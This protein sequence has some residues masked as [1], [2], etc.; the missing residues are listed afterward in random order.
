MRAVWKLGNT[1]RVYEAQSVCKNYS[2]IAG[3][4]PRRTSS[5]GVLAGH[6]AMSGS[7]ALSHGVPLPLHGIL[8][9][10]VPLWVIHHSTLESSSGC[11]LY[12]G[13]NMR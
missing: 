10:N 1:E 11:G 4:D 12:M 13:F 8:I 7:H 9:A 2:S 3:V 5:Y 6:P